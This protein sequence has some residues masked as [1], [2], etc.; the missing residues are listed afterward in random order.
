MKYIANILML[1][2]VVLSCTSPKNTDKA[3]QTTENV[4]QQKLLTSDYYKGYQ[5][6]CD[7]LINLYAFERK[8]FFSIAARFY[9]GKDVKQALKDLEQL[10]ENPSGDMFWVHQFIIVQYFGKDY[11][12][13]DLQKKLRDVWRTYT[14][15]RGDTENHWAMTYM[16]YYLITQLYPD[17]PGETWFNG[18]SSQEIHNEA[19]EYLYDWMR[20]TTSIGQGE[21]DSPNYI[22]CFVSPM[23]M[24]YAF[25]EDEEMKQKAGMMLDYLL[26]DFA[27]ESLDGFYGGAHS[28]IYPPQAFNGWLSDSAGFSWLLFGNTEKRLVHWACTLAMS[29]YRP[30]EIL[31]HIATDRSQPYVHKE[32]KRTRHR[33][34][35]SDVKNAPVYKYTYMRNEYVLGSLQGGLLQ[36]IQQHSWDITW[37]IDKPSDGKNTIFCNHPYVAG[38]ELS[39]YFP[40][41]KDLLVEYIISGPVAKKS[42]N[43]PA[44][45]TGAS[46][47]EQIVQHK[48]ALIALYDIPEGTHY[49]HINA[50]FPK[51]LETREIDESGW[52]FCRGGDAWMAYYPLQKYEWFDDD[53]FWRMESH[54][55]QN[56]AVFQAAPASSYASMDEFKKAVL[57]CA[58]ETKV[59]PKPGVNFTSLDGTEMSFTYDQVPLI[60]NKPVDYEH[61]KLYEGPF[62][63]ADR[64]SHLL[65]MSYGNMH[66]KLDFNTNTV[67]NWID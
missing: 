49:E 13:K 46:P 17:D 24:L 62:L 64:N 56:G 60:N 59:D 15:N 41:H 63:N 6:R 8:G 7:E 23:A 34:R 18:R 12:P 27:A 58:L 40:E 25:A 37:A 28:R 33:I 54:Y 47:F 35:N 53:G 4:Q 16:S 48:D 42:Y 50:F 52:I 66:R 38:F 29:G 22:G 30:P 20:I 43:Q 61:W 32:Y 5:S 3:Q 11:I 9:T 67:T 31:Y 36:P 19:K 2:F 10:I 51:N 45:R 65:N 14:P 21:F 26:A 1:L 57:A 39:M 44:K 55:R